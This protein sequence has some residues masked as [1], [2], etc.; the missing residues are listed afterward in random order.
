MT[1]FIISII[2]W[3]VIGVVQI[4]NQKDGRKPSWGD[5]WIM[6]FLFLFN[7][8]MYQLSVLL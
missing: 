6:Y 4:I 2:I 8:T 5:Y 7:F 3:A 1:M